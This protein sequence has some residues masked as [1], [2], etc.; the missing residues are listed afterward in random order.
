MPS[1]TRAALAPISP[2]L[3]TGV[4][5]RDFIKGVALSAASI[6]CGVAR[7]QASAEL[8]RVPLGLDAHSLRAMRWQA[9]QLIEYA[10]EQKLDALLLNTLKPFESL[11]NDHLRKLKD[12]AEA[13]GLR[14]YIGVGSVAEGSATF[15]KEHGNAEALLALGVRVATA[16]GSPVVNCRIGAFPDRSTPGG[17]EARMDELVRVLKAGRSRAQDAGV[18]FAIENHAGDLRSEEVLQVIQAAGTD[19]VG[20]MLDPG[21]AVWAMEDPMHQLDLLGRHVL[22]T[23]VRDYMVWET[24]EGAT[25]QWTALGE[26]LMDVPAYV[27]KMAELCPSAPLHLEIISNSPRPIPYLKPEYWEVYPHLRAAGIVHFLALCRRGRA[28]KVETAPAG[29]SAREFD[30]QHQRAEL[31]RSFA[32]ARRHGAGL[33][34]V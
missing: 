2:S 34:S 7:G 13:R 1:N 26:G 3:I 9:R 11:E 25:F 33:K 8:K 4:R 31:E 21:N 30:Q 10:G 32:A 28:L 27:G 17:I 6:A 16:V 23:S 15:S 20:V 5:R 12:D 22:C 19:V 14:I 24:A 18:K 29:M